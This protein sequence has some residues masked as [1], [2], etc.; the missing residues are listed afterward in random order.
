MISR[1]AVKYKTH[2]MPCKVITLFLILSIVSV[3]MCFFIFSLKKTSSY[4]N[5]CRRLRKIACVRVQYEEGTHP[6]YS[7]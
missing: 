2:E 7:S 1:R 3:Y 4:M 6:P 5:M